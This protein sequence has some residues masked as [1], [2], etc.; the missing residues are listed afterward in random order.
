[1]TIHETHRHTFAV[2]DLG[3]TDNDQD[4]SIVSSIKTILQKEGIDCVVDGD[5]MNPAS[6]TVWTYSPR[7]VVEQTLMADGIDL[8]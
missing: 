1:M 2:A 4:R 6:F 7:D 8:E 3:D 5:E